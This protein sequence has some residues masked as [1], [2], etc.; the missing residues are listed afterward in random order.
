MSH[1]SKQIMAAAVPP[2]RQHHFVRLMRYSKE[3]LAANLSCSFPGPSYA[4]LDSIDTAAMARRANKLYAWL[5]A[6][7]ERAGKILN[8]GCKTKAQLVF[9]KKFARTRKQFDALIAKIDVRLI[10]KKDKRS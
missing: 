6:H 5:A 2:D 10:R 1:K 4:L 7:E 8:D 3:A 9:L